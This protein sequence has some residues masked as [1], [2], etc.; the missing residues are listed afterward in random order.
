MKLIFN[1]LIFIYFSVLIVNSFL[2]GIDLNWQGNAVQLF[3]DETGFYNY[4]PSSILENGIE[5]HFY[6]V[7]K[8]PF[9]IFDHIGLTQVRHSDHAVVASKQIVLSPETNGIWQH[10]AGVWNGPSNSLTI[11]VNGKQVAQ[12]T[13]TG[14]PHLKNLGGFRVIGGSLNPANR[15]TFN[16]SID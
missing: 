16:G 12:K 5:F 2:F 9:K 6:C 4:A 10:V 11:Y 7:N 3:S 8:D 14:N 15:Q 13:E 1:K